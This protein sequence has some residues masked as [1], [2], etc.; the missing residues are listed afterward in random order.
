MIHFKANA[1]LNYK[2][3]DLILFSLTY[4]D[5]S[6]R[7]HCELHLAT[8][9][10]HMTPSQ[11][12]MDAKPRQGP[13]SLAGAPGFLLASGNLQGS[14]LRPDFIVLMSVLEG[15]CFSIVFLCLLEQ[16]YK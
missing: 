8:S 6:R 1:F 4:F 16:G 15:S 3:H 14:F 9:L 13:Q 12:S 5:S 2:S 10:P 7:G 11:H